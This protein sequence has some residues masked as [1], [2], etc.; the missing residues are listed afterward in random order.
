M[1]NVLHKTEL[2]RLSRSFSEA[3][4]A[5]R[6]RLARHLHACGPRPLLEALIAVDSG[7]P[8][9]HVLDDFGRLAPEI[10]R[11]VGADALP[12]DQPLAVLKGGRDDG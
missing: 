8:L 9:D 12:I 5:K 4:N 3:R 6:Q 1:S 11:V 7:Q 10:Y 2:L